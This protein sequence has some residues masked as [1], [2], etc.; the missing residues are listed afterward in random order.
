M[1]NITA[2][3]IRWAEEH[4]TRMMTW[5]G[6]IGHKLHIRVECLSALA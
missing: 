1:K 3:L 4:I 2:Y 6:Q 5:G